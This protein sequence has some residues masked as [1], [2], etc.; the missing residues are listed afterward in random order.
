MNVLV[1]GCGKVGYYLARTLREH[2]HH[3]TV[4]ETDRQRA[5]RSANELDMVVYCGDGTTID[6]LEAAGCAKMDALVAVTGSD[7]N[8]LIACQLAKKLFH[9]ERTV[10][11]VNN[12]KNTA[13]LK[14]LGV[15]I[16]LSSTDVLA[17]LIEREVDSAA[18][19]QIVA[20]NKGEASI[21]EITLPDNYRLSGVRL[22]ELDL[23]EESIIVSISRDDQM[24]IPR[25]NTQL[26]GGDRIIIVCHNR[27]LHQLSQQLHL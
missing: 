25:G 16:A 1:I 9:V 20:L 19:R 15:D 2:G 27:A 18:I 10:A 3:P 17:R 22:R 6:M 7:Q 12:P 14:Q 26:M 21:N 23:P 11:R 24:I 13:I 5:K 8:N 4:I